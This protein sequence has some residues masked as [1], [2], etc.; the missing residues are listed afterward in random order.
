MCEME[1]EG[2]VGQG[3]LYVCEVEWDRY[4]GQGN[5]CVCMWSGRGM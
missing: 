1:W 4:V 2:Y 3:N 5:L